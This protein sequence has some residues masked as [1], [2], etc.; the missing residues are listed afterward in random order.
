MSIAGVVLA[1]GY[2]SRAGC[3][4]MTQTLRGKPVI[5][6]VIG[7]MDSICDRIVV[8]TGFGCERLLYLATLYPKVQL[9]YNKEFNDGM[10]SSVIAGIRQCEADRVFITPGDCA[11]VSVNT[12][13][14]LAKAKG[15]ISVPFYHGLAGHPICIGRRAVNRLLH[16]GYTSLHKFIDVYKYNAIEIEDKG[17][18]MDLDT[19]EDFQ[20]VETYLNGLTVCL[21]SLQGR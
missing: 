21:Q 19:P 8:V 10:F 11:A 7:A 14:M 17:I 6:H 16:G 12:Y 20:R 5:E 15:E 2:S 4:K 18:L 1:A 13:R 9:I 3:F